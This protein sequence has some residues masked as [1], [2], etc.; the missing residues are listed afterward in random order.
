M[1]AVW[2]RR[3]VL[4]AISILAV[5]AM[6]AAAISSLGTIR[7]LGSFHASM[8]TGSP[9]G[10]YYNLGSQ[11]AERAKRDGAQLDVVVTEGSVENVSRLV[12]DRQGCVSQFAFV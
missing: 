9:G 7:D 12:A 4:R 2:R 3:G 1:S 5:S 10:A 8:L 11:L 6:I